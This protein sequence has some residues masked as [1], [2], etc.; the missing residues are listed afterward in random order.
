MTVPTLMQNHQRKVYVTQLHKVYNELQQAFLQKMTDKNAINLIEAGLTT[1]AS[2]KTFLHDYFKVVQ[3]CEKGVTEPCFVNNY[4][5]I[6]GGLF[7]GVNSNGWTGGACVIISS[8]AA[9]CLDRPN[10]GTTTSEDGITITRGN[11]FI[12]IN[13][14]KG[15]NIVGRDAFYMSIFSDGILDTGNASYDC[16]TNGV[17]RGGSIDKA[18]LLGNACEDTSTLNDY[19]CFG[20]ILNDNWEM[21]Y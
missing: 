11:V 20:K 4:K 16:R 12:D 8:G 18:R 10:F 15:P 13:G 21:T 7:S 2:M 3:D 14:T 6:N 9:I 1:R 17:C 5:N 19:A